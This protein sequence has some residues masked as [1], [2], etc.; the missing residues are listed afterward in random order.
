MSP[1]HLGHWGVTASHAAVGLAL[2][3]LA[4]TG[5]GWLLGVDV[6]WLCRAVVWGAPIV[7]AVW[8]LYVHLEATQ[9]AAGYVAGMHCDV[10]FRHTV[11]IS[12]SCY[13][14][15][16]FLLLLFLLFLLLRPVSS[17]AIGS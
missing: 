10:L 16:L 11:L 6:A 5:C 13:P 1:R 14:S 17:S 4:L 7:L 9:G 8:S 2:G 15:L 3:H 12:L